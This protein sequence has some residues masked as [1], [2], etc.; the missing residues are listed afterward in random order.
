[1]TANPR[2]RWLCSGMSYRAAGCELNNSEFTV[3]IKQGV[4]KQKH[5]TEVIYWSCG[6]NVATRGWQEANSAFLRGGWFSVGEFSVR[7]DSADH[8]YLEWQ[9]VTACL[10]KKW[11]N[12]RHTGPRVTWDMRQCTSFWRWKLLLLLLWT[13]H[14]KPAHILRSP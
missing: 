5:I 2:V 10:C 8:N 6:K 1:M 3:C 7:G 14:A 13:E 9:E 11:T 4:Y 12:Q